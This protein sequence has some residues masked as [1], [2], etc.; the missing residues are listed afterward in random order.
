MLVLLKDEPY[1]DTPQNL[2]DK[3]V[4]QRIFPSEMV[5]FN[6][7]SKSFVLKDIHP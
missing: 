1:F 3:E 2:I 6:P 7:H 5:N 4:F